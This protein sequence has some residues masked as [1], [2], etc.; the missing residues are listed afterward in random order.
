MEEYA[1]KQNVFR[2]PPMPTL[3]PSPFGVLSSSASSLDL[4]GVLMSSAGPGFSSGPAAK[5]AGFVVFCKEKKPNFRD[6]QPARERSKANSDKMTS[7]MPR[8][9]LGAMLSPRKI[10][11]PKTPKMGVV[12]RNIPARPGAIPFSPMM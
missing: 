4:S 12:V 8:S 1:L 5:P 6:H 10:M 3:E 9:W 11:A 2:K 7:T